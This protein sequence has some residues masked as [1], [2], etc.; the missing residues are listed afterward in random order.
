M[1]IGEGLSNPVRDV[2][3]IEVDFTVFFEFEPVEAEAKLPGNLMQDSV[4]LPETFK[5]KSNVAFHVWTFI[6]WVLGSLRL[7]FVEG[8]F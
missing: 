8:R 6:S 1:L 5:R 3:T 7:L 4:L 2:V